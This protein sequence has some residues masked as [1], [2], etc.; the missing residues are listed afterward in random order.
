MLYMV[1]L[2]YS[3]EHRDDALKYFLEHG[4]TH[5]EGNITVQNA[6]VAT[7]DHVAYALVRTPSGDEVDKASRSPNSARSLVGASPAPT[8]FEPKTRY[9]SFATVAALRATSCADGFRAKSQR[10]RRRC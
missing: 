10:P 3:H 5:Y 1:E 9:L 2:H 4:A 7:R 8:R 6:W